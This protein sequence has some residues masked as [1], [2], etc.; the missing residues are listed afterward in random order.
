[1]K[2]GNEVFLYPHH[3][4]N[5]LSFIWSIVIL[6]RIANNRFLVIFCVNIKKPLFSEWL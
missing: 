3:Y 6:E 1:M 5:I 2:R 4:F